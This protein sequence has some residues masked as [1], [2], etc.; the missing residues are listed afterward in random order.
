[1]KYTF[2]ALF[3]YF[4]LFFLVF[5]DS[6]FAVTKTIRIKNENTPIESR[7]RINTLREILYSTAMQFD[8]TKLVVIIDG[9]QREP[10]GR[11]RDAK[12]SLS[13]YIA[14][15]T[16]FAK[17]FI[18]ELAHYIDIYSIA[19]DAIR[20]DISEDFYQI[21]WQKPTVK[22][23]N[24]NTLDFVS[25]YAATNQYEDFAESFVFYVFHNSTFADRALRSESIREKYLFFANYIFPGGFFQGTDFSIGRVPSYVWDT[26]KISYSLQKYLYSL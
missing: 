22:R 14:R 18:H 24:Q 1:M 26:T 12:I 25:G 5:Q 21:S 8:Y 15:D 4:S 19:S 9:L 20:D 7:H 23:A 2:S 10:R 11:M 16:E 3:I 17:L 13:P 6:A